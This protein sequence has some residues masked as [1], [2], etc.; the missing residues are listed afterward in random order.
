MPSRWEAMIDVLSR[1]GRVG[2]A[3]AAAGLAGGTFAA[4]PK[5]GT[6][7]VVRG[8]GAFRTPAGA[9]R[10]A[11]GV[12]WVGLGNG[13]VEASWN[14]AEGSLRPA[15]FLDRLSG[16]TYR[17]PAELFTVE[18]AGG[19]TIAASRL[20]LRG[21]PRAEAV[22]GD[23]SA[24]SL[25][26]RL[27]GER[28][29]AVFEDPKTGLRVT[30][31][32][33]GRDGTRYLRQEIS[34]EAGKT[35]LPVRRIVMLD[36][37]L[38][39]ATRAGTARG[40][41]V[42]SRD[43][44]CAIESPMAE[45]TVAH[46]RVIC[47]L[48]RKVPLSR[49]QVLTCSSVIGVTR[50]GQLRRDFEQYV[51]DERAHPYRPFLQYNTWY[52][53]GY[54]YVPPYNEAGALAAIDAFG[55]QLVRDRGV[56]IDSFVFDDGWDD[57]RT[58]WNFN[59]GFPDGFSRVQAEAARYGA[60]PGVWLSPWG[61]YGEARTLRLK[62]ARR[63]GFEINAQ[64]LALS[65]PRYFAYFR[66]K[67]LGMI[68]RYGINQFKFDGI[69]DATGRYPGSR[70]GSDFEAAIQLIRDLRA[71]K[72]DLYVN[73]TTGTWPSPFWLRYADSIWRGGEDHD[74]AGVGSK[75]Q[76]W[77]TYRDEEVYRNV[78]RTSPL[79]PLNS[80][81]LH[82]II[83]AVHANGLYDDPG[84]DFASG[85]R[86][87]FGS[88][89][90]CQE[91]YITPRL[92]TK[93]DWDVLAE[94]ARWARSNAGTLRDTHWI[95][96]D[97]GAGQ[98]YGW[99]AWSGGAGILVLRNPSDRPSRIGV[100]VGAAFE[101][102]AGAARRYLA[103]SPWSEDRAQPSLELRAGCTHV[104]DLRAFEVLTLDARPVAGRN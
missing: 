94:A 11:A 39:F 16:K 98:V 5:T 55:R 75:R 66:A 3:L 30:W 40:V 59:S 27:P 63:Q 18:L 74:F 64:G 38:P 83:Y 35:D 19:E 7:A 65:G 15:N 25:A 43:L 89:T 1:L 21:V 14:I 48:E 6:P 41:P 29:V 62:F 44:F 80:L 57:R 10:A 77:I 88:G 32:A 97:P 9:F 79:F 96:G 26:R 104:F 103:H 49:G 54:F 13:A 33:I 73:L 101:L 95:G 102:P 2:C 24:S 46:G 82:G 72:P 69:G 8:S 31:S 84:G 22:R 71:A 92:L 4:G 50:P 81:M 20:E 76:Q 100:D 34:L 58:L 67:C 61:G 86:D 91:M 70:F 42:L 85:V 99:A 17:L 28:I 12:G 45:N 36:W 23:P 53:L 37:A 87:F 56:K 47:A 51:E 90:Q 60:A 78:V 52:D 68:E 93:A